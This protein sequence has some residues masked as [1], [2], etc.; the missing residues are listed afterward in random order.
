MEEKPVEP[1]HTSDE[2]SSIPIIYILN[3]FST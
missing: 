3:P 1:F 2:L